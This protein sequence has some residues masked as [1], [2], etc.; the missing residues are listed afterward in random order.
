MAQHNLWCWYKV[1][2]QGCDD[3][4]FVNNWTILQDNILPRSCYNDMIGRCYCA[5]I[6][7]LM[8]QQCTNVGPTTTDDVVQMGVNN[9]CANIARLVGHQCI[10]VRSTTTGGVVPM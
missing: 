2:I 7:K 9:I 3:V 4:V 1:V 10:N 5:N 6:G 8:D